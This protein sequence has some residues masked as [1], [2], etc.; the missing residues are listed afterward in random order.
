MDL[1]DSFALY[2]PVMPFGFGGC[3]GDEGEGGGGVI[4]FEVQ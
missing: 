1:S 4:F 2:I 3:W